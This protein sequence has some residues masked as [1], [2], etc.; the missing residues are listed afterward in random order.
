MTPKQAEAQLLQSVIE[1]R[2]PGAIGQIAAAC[3]AG[4]DPNGLCPETSSSRGP[5]RAGR[6]LLTHAIQDWSSRVVEKL[7]EC[8]ADP[9]LADRLGWTPWMAST[10]VDES[11]RSRIQGLLLQFGARPE[12]DGIRALADAIYDGCVERAAALLESAPDLERLSAFRVDLVRHT[13]FKQNTAMLELLIRHG[14]RPDAEHLSWTVRGRY[15]VGAD[16]LLR[17]GASPEGTGTNESLL[18]EAAALGEM[19]IVQRLVEAGADVNRYAWDNIEW[20]AAYSARRAGH[21]DIADWLTSRMD[22]ALLEKIRRLT[23]ARDPKDRS[24]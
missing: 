20:T 12:G 8:G 21:R 7:L 24:L 11:K 16:L 4:A 3:A 13:I 19:A 23:Q 9:N 5:V 18:M 10:L 6:T 17:H 22:E 15:L 14:L 1:P 2:R